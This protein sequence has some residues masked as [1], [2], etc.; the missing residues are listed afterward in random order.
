MLYLPFLS[1]LLVSLITTSSD[2][3]L[4]F[5]CSFSKA[6][7][8]GKILQTYLKFTSASIQ[9]FIPNLS[10]LFGIKTIKGHLLFIGKS[11]WLIHCQSPIQFVVFNAVGNQCFHRFTDMY[12]LIGYQYLTSAIFVFKSNN[13]FYF[14]KV[15]S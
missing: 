15:R 2:R 1:K 3:G 6:P 7:R 12:R 5:C 11:C 9:N 14:Y 8:Y 13:F 4:P 10:G